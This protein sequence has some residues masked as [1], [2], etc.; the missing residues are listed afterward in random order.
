MAEVYTSDI[1]STIDKLQVQLNEI[2]KAQNELVETISKLRS[3][4]I[5]Q[6]EINKMKA[7]VG[8]YVHYMEQVTNYNSKLLSLKAAMSMLSGRSQQL[9]RRAEKLKTLKLNHLSRTDHIRKIEQEKDL[10]IAARTSTPQQSSPESIPKVKSIKKKK[11]S[12]A[13]IIE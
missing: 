12:K 7:N 8:A 1:A 6:E 4:S 3:N 9:Q 10:T 5:M 13:V 11:K 2:T